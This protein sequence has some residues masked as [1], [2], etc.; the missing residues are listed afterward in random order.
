MGEGGRL[1]RGFTSSRRG[2]Q[3]RTSRVRRGGAGLGGPEG[4]HGGPERAG[5]YNVCGFMGVRGPQTLR[6]EE[7]GVA[8]GGS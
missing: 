6:A 2:A 3:R 5:N 7:L 1:R 8:V 4:A